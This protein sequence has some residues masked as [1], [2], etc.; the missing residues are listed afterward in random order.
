MHSI[1]RLFLLRRSLVMRGLQLHRFLNHRILPLPPLIPGVLQTRTISYRI[2]DQLTFKGLL[3]SSFPDNVDV[4]KLLS[5]KATIY[6]GF[7]PTAPS[8][9]LGNLLVLVSLLHL[10]HH[11]HRV[12]VLI[13]DATAQIGD[14]S[15][16]ATEQPPIE[17]DVVRAN[18]DGIEADVRRVLANYQQHFSTH[19]I[20][21]ENIIIT[22]NGSWY[23]HLTAIE[24]LSHYGCHL[25]MGHLLSKSSTVN[26]HNGHDLIKKCLGDYATYGLFAQFIT[27][28]VSSSPLFALYQYCMRRTD[29]EVNRL[30]QAFSF[31]P[32]REVETVLQAQL[33][34]PT[35]WRLQKLLARQL[36]TL[37][38]GQEGLA[39]AT[40]ITDAFFTRDLAFLGAL[41]PAELAKVFSGAE[42]YLLEFVLGGHLTAFDLALRTRCFD[43]PLAAVN[44]IEEG[45]FYLNYAQVDRPSL[46]FTEQHILPNHITIVSV[47][48]KSHRLVR[49][50]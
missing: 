14:P 34:S 35:P 27:D 31:R 17:A 15:G 2:Y 6:A 23:S 26:I 36:T 42:E 39:T 43:S 47:G 41:S 46:P 45:G 44:T 10:L 12:I 50:L 16:R 18:A 40:R 20:L 21:Q 24:L 33:T 13:G 5:S 9:H 8:L 49:W 37:V 7:D 29:G 28:E 25:C 19:R 38:H 48:K 3:C 11:G 1:V 32:E 30:L 4:N 22:R